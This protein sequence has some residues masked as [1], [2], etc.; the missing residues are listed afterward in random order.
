MVGRIDDGQAYICGWQA[1]LPHHQVMGQVCVCVPPVLHLEP[2]LA[3]RAGLQ[4]PPGG[5][6]ALLDIAPSARVSC[7]FGS[8]GQLRDG[9]H[10]IREIDLHRMYP[11]AAAQVYQKPGGGILPGSFPPGLH[12]LVHHVGGV[13]FRAI[14]AAGGGGLPVA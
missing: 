3:V 14:A 5:E 12:V 13:L 7:K 11:A 9:L 4:E 6:G 10:I 2:M 1:V 8:L